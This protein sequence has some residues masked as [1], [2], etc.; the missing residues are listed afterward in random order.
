MNKDL[1]RLDRIKCDENGWKYFW[2]KNGA[3]FAKK[4]EY[5]N[6]KNFKL[7]GNWTKT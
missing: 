4:R 3:I 5:R 7:E 1:F 2:T 6:S